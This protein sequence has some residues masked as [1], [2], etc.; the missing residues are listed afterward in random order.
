MMKFNKILIL[1]STY[2]TQL[3]VQR[4]LNTKY[5]LVGYVPSRRTPIDGNIP[6]PEVS[7]ESDCDIILSVQYDRYIENP[8]NIYNLHTGLLPDY[9]GLDILRHTIEE[10]VKEQGVTFHKMTDKYDY[11]PIISKITYPVF[12][13]DTIKSLYKRQCS[14]VPDFVISCLTLLEN[15]N[16]EDINKCNTEEPRLMDRVYQKTPFVLSDEEKNIMEKTS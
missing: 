1:G 15:M 7:I 13:N 3:V 9:G 4:L 12:E 16:E 11:G 14:V 6:L 5:E 10:N 8:Q 2:L